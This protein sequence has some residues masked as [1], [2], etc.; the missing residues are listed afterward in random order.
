MQKYILT[1]AFDKDYLSELS[2]MIGNGFIWITDAI[3]IS[4]SEFEKLKEEE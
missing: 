1:I 2:T 4:D 3:E